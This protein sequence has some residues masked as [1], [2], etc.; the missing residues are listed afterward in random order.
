MFTDHEIVATDRA[1]VT[2]TAVIAIKVKLADSTVCFSS[3]GA[4]GTVMNEL[5][6]RTY[7]Y[8]SEK[9]KL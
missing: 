7:T 1:V 6:S 4:K 5:S 8:D 9:E 2:D 3:P